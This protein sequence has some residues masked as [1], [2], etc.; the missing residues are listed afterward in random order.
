MTARSLRVTLP[1]RA[2]RRTTGSRWW[3]L[4]VFNA[5]RPRAARQAG[6]QQSC[7]LILI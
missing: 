2:P 4:Q 3:R 7:D 6:R 5:S 1:Y